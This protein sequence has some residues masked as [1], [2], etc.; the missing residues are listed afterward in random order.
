MPDYKQATTAATTWQRCNQIVIDNPRQ[1]APSVRFDEETVTAMAL[2]D[3]IRR[4][5]G[6]LS[7]PFDPA[8]PIPL[9]DPATGELTGQ[10]SSYGAA[11]VLL[12]SAYMAAAQAR[13]TAAAPAPQPPIV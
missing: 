9:R 7:L 13:D 2:G 11:Y 5:V 4:P 1:G 8:Q 12:F 6:T 10:T 3:E